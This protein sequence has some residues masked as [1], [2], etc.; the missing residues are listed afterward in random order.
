MLKC[1]SM[2]EKVILPEYLKQSVTMP[3][4]ENVSIDTRIS[5]VRLKITQQ[6]TLRYCIA[7]RITGTLHL[8][9]KFEISGEY[10]LLNTEDTH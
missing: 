1:I 10:V 9:K 8:D 2:L 7:E 5:K 4:Q 3:I 6:Y